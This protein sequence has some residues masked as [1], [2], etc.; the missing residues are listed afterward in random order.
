MLCE[1]WL[2]IQSD[3]LITWIEDIKK[4]YIAKK[5]LCEDGKEIKKQKMN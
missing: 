4:K 3:R 1:L 2:L 5:N